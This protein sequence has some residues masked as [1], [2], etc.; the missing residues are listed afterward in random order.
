M[1]CQWIALCWR[2]LYPSAD[3]RRQRG[4]ASYHLELQPNFQDAEVIS[5]P[6]NLV[7]YPGEICSAAGSLSQ[8]F[9]LSDY[10]P[11]GNALNDCKRLHSVCRPAR[12]ERRQWVDCC[13][14]AVDESRFAQ[15]PLLR[16]FEH[17]SSHGEVGIQLAIGR[18]DACFGRG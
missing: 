7:T 8:R 16:Q 6:L 13:H 1:A 4:Q 15:L 9:M 3:S 18:D 14:Q 17:Q 12:P 10:S 5:F 2:L 11:L